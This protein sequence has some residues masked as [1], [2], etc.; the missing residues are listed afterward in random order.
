MYTVNELYQESFLII[1]K[2]RT[3]FKR[4]NKEQWIT[5]CTQQSLPI[6]SGQFTRCEYTE[7]QLVRKK[8]V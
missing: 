3:S 1:N 6:L 5:G 7:N 8:N 2:A 4:V